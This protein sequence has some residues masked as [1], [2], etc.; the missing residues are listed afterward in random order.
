MRQKDV[1]RIFSK[2]PT[3]CTPRLVLR[4]LRVGDAEDMFEYASRADVTRYLTWQPHPSRNYTR[5]FLEFIG[6]K[7]RLGEYFDWAVVCRGD[8]AEPKMIGTCGF[9]RINCSDN[10]AEAGY[11]INPRYRGQAL[12]PEALARVIR[13]G[14]K[15]MK[16]NRIEARYI[17]GNDPSRRV[18]EKVGMRFEGILRSSLYLR[19]EYRD[20]GVCSILA[21]EY[22]SSLKT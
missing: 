3:L 8:A 12:A 20:V 17:V 10:S 21:R 6:T 2:P 16:L 18:M 1:K 7:Y 19:G 14:F 22:F 13:F 15:E 5:E 11:V 4:E 9:S